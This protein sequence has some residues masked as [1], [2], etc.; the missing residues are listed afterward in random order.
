MRGR[1][2]KGE[3]EREVAKWERKGDF[4]GLGWILKIKSPFS[5]PLKKGEI[6]GEI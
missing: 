1:L 5:P 2:K 4:G 6:G 3:D